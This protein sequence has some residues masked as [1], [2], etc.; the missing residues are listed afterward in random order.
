MGS[1][2]G[3]AL[4]EADTG[5]KAIDIGLESDSELHRVIV[6][7]VRQFG[8]RS[9]VPQA[10]GTVLWGIRVNLDSDAGTGDFNVSAVIDRTG[11]KGNLGGCCRSG[12]GI[13]PVAAALSCVPG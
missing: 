9:V 13:T 5:N 2:I 11:F 12:P 7:T 4:I 3:D 10:A 8:N 6:K 1:R